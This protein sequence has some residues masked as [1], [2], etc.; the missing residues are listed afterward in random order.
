MVL[1]FQVRANGLYDPQV[2]TGGHQ[3][4]GFDEFM[5]TYD[6]YTVH[7]S[8]ASGSFMYEGYNGPVALSSTGDLTQNIHTTHI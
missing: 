6:M 8:R 3:P 7:G 5:T 1:Q 4:R 2:S